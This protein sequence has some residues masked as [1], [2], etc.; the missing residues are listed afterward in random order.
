[1][2]A[3]AAEGGYGPG[4]L[5]PGEHDAGE[6]GAGEHGLSEHGADGQGVSEQNPGGQG[7]GRRGPNDAPATK[8]LCATVLIMETVVIWLA[9]PVALAV[10]HA[11]PRHAGVAGVVLAVVAVVL[12][13]VARRRL[14]WTIVGGSVLQ[15]LII[16][17]GVIVPVMYFLGAIF[18]AFW[19]IGLRLGHRLDVAS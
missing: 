5:G 3:A 7:P 18:A 13:A 2:T 16:A 11:S 17:A 15:A 8:R 19:V 10:D 6:H 1:M 14:R 12:A 9:I 4:Q